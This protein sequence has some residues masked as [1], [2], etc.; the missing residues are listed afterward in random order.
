MRHLLAAALV[1]VVFVVARL[2]SSVPLPKSPDYAIPLAQI[3][4]E[5]RA[6]GLADAIHVEVIGEAELPGWA[7]TAWNGFG[8]DQRVFTSFQVVSDSETLVIDAPH[9][10]RL[11]GVVPGATAY[12]EQAFDRMQ[13][14]LETASEL[15]ITHIHGDH[16]AGHDVGG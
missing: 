12:D 6:V 9:P 8:K 10:A 7:T 2:L 3:R 15:Y 14:G 5:V 13:R 4:S 16:V 11:H 1:V